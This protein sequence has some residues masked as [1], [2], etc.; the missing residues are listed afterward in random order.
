MVVSRRTPSC[1]RHDG[2]ITVPGCEG[3]VISDVQLRVVNV[4]LVMTDGPFCCFLGPDRIGPPESYDA[5]TDGDAK[6]SGFRFGAAT[7]GTTS[8][9]RRR[10]EQ[11][12]SR[13]DHLGA[14]EP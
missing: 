12:R 10:F 5:R 3:E 13:G 2:L 6:P 9:R 1:R 14:R 7:P 4:K 8:P 11:C